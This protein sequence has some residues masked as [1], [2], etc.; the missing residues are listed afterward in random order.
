MPRLPTSIDPADL[1][2]ALG[3]AGDSLHAAARSL[4]EPIDYLPLL[5][6]R[7]AAVRALDARIQRGLSDVQRAAW[8]LDRLPRE[9]GSS[10]A[11]GLEQVGQALDELEHG[12]RKAIVEPR[13]SR[14]FDQYRLMRGHGVVVADLA[15]GLHALRSDQ[16]SGWLEV[17]PAVAR[18][19]RARAYDRR[20]AIVAMS[21]HWGPKLDGWLPTS[22]DT[23]TW[24]LAH[25]RLRF[26]VD[27]DPTDAPHQGM[28]QLAQQAWGHQVRKVDADDLRRM[29]R[30]LD[31]PWEPPWLADAAGDIV[32]DPEKVADLVVASNLS[33]PEQLQLRAAHFLVNEWRYDFGRNQDT[34]RDIVAAMRRLPDEL[35]PDL[36][37]GI[38]DDFDA[39]LEWTRELRTAKAR[40]FVADR[41]VDERVLVELLEQDELGPLGRVQVARELLAEVPRRSPQHAIA[42]DTLDELSASFLQANERSW[43]VEEADF[44]RVRAAARLVRRIAELDVPAATQADAAG[45]AW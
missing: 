8:H 3:A 35:R 17:P 2:R 18:A 24:Q 38:E 22:S 30:S 1:Q 45:I 31:V 9:P 37:P 27:V 39:A 11:L 25:N 14:R 32:L 33:K 26:M 41:P 28:W 34:G 7:K 36:P 20:H 43:H 40:A 19:N 12:L 21:P 44:G 15:D 13:S 23:W 5:S 10:M 29:V 16:F 4:T 6:G 42:M